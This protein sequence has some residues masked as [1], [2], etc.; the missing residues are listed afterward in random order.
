[1]RFTHLHLLLSVS[2]SIYHASAASSQIVY[3]ANHAE[4]FAGNSSERIYFL[5]LGA[6]S[7]HQNAKN[8]SKNIQ[9]Q[10]H[11]PVYVE[12]L[13]GTY[14]VRVGPLNS[15][16]LRQT[17]ALLSGKSKE[18]PIKSV[19]KSNSKQ[20][21]R[22]AKEHTEVISSA[23]KPDNSWYA[24]VKIGIQRG[25][26]DDSITIHNGSGLPAPYNQDIY[27]SQSSSSAVSGVGAGYRFTQ[28]GLPAISVGLSYSHFFNGQSGDTITQYSLPEFINY[29]YQ[30]KVASDLV[31]A[32]SKLNIY[33]WNTLLPF[34]QAGAGF[35]ANRA[36]K[37]KEAAFSDVT[38]RY[39]PS[40]TNKTTT[41]FAYQLGAGLDWQI[42]PQWFVSIGY[43][44]TDLGHF[45]SGA[46]ANGW[47]SEALKSEHLFSNAAILGV[48]YSFLDN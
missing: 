30:W 46:G 19:A 39:S 17:G 42:K 27:T 45:S 4:H 21:T 3:G 20:I 24:A 2:F 5:Q 33:N 10:T 1:M 13:S 14:L 8:F 26:S 44:Y 47:N 32:S 18:H 29:Q 48:T 7:N 35:S 40:F 37:Y 31:L 25:T 22:V 6:F 11:H 23:V 41:S 12:H 28:Y 43:E 34:V 36:R 15:R 16:E 38:P 9:A